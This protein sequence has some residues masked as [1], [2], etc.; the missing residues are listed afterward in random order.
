MV[1]TDLEQVIILFFMMM[2]GFFLGKRRY[3]DRKGTNLLSKL[4]LDVFFPCN[5]LAAASGDFGSMAFGQMIGIIFFYIFCFLLYTFLSG[6]LSKLL[7][8]KQD[9]ELVFTRSVSYPNNGFVGIPLCTAIFGAQGSVV[10]ALS[11]PCTALYMLFG[12]MQSFQRREKTNK[13]FIQAK[14]IATTVNFATLAMLVMVV[15][16]WRFSGFIL[17][18]L[19]GFGNCVLPTSM[20]II[21]CLLSEGHLIDALKNPLIY[22]ITFLRGIAAP[23]LAALL[24]RFSGWDHGICLPIVAVLGC[25]VATVVSIFAVRYDRSPML[26]SQSVL[27]SNLLLPVTMPVVMMLAEKIV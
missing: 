3:V 20:L 21:G 6:L 17:H 8:L 4:L 22:L 9:D 12:V 7:R 24:L 2:V 18:F 27:Q 11:V 19:N 16:G 14:D 1:Q 5:V 26:A 25:S 13:D 23:L 10:A 15:N